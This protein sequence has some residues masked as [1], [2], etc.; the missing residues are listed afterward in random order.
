MVAVE[1]GDLTLGD[2]LEGADTSTIS[3]GTRR[4]LGL[5]LGGGVGVEEVGASRGADIS[6][7]WRFCAVFGRNNHFRERISNG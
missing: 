1:V 4:R 7:G 2:V 5:D 6:A 3:M